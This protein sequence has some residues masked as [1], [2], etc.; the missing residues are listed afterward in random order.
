MQLRA[1][2][3]LCM[4]LSHHSRVLVCVLCPSRTCAALGAAAGNY[5]ARTMK[6][7][8]LPQM[9]SCVCVMFSCASVMVRLSCGSCDTW[10]PW[11]SSHHHLAHPYASQLHQASEHVCACV[12]CVC[13][14]VCVY[15]CV[16]VPVFL[17]ERVH[18]PTNVCVCVH[19]CVW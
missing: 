12:T 14:C 16:F 5:V 6:I 17:H 10:E 18:L 4:E 11:D 7:T 2:P 13:V 9:V 8:D 3:S 19:V 1:H 15:A